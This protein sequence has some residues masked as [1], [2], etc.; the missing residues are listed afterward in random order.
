MCSGL[1][2]PYVFLTFTAV[3]RPLSDRVASKYVLGFSDANFVCIFVVCVVPTSKDD[4]RA[5]AVYFNSS[6]A[7]VPRTFLEI[8]CRCGATDYCCVRL[9]NAVCNIPFFVVLHSP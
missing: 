9:F 3:A 8:C 2:L 5:I 4:P 6:T 7:D 1:E